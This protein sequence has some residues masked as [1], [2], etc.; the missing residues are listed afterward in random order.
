MAVLKQGVPTA[1]AKCLEF[2]KLGICGTEVHFLMDSGAIPNVLSKALCLLLGLTPEK[3][4]KIITTATGD[5]SAVLGAL[6]NLPIS[7]DHV[8]ELVDFLFI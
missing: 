8:V 4:K 5:T 1:E 6:K 2:A 7:F 3:S